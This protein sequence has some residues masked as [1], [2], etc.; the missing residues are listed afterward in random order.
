MLLL[1]WGNLAFADDEQ[2]SSSSTIVEDS[3][4]DSPGTPLG[5]HSPVTDDIGTGWQTTFGSNFAIDS[6][7][8]A[9]SDPTGLNT[10][11][12]SIIDGR[13]ETID[14]TVEFTRSGQSSEVG[15]VFRWIDPSNHFRVEFD[16]KKGRIVKVIAGVETELGSKKAKWKAGKSKTIR[17][18]DNAGTIQLRLDRKKV[19]TVSDSDLLGETRIGM[20]YRN[21][22]TTAVRD[23]AVKSAAP[24]ATPPTVTRGPVVVQDTFDSGAGP[25]H[26]RPAD[27]VSGEPEWA[28]IVGTWEVTTGGDAR[29][30]SRTGGGDQIT[31]IPTGI[32]D[33][34][35]SADI[36][37][38]GGV[39]GL[40]WAVDASNDRS[41]RVG[42]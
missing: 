3:F 5:A 36:T 19:S 7:G 28:D 18:I 16:G 20:Y 9:A 39:T 17:V 10:P 4:F 38:N 23:F 14:L 13:L 41:I 35:I 24:L 2:H 26:L 33:A 15:L 21:D 27:N 12:F 8:S 11:Y 32:D 1:V 25:L 6:T 31:A 37:W 42:D 40:A 30:V 22:S 34:D 29:L